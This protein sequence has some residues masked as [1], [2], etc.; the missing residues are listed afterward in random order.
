M[1]KY[2]ILFA[3]LV[4]IFGC[5]GDNLTG[6]S[7]GSANRMITDGWALYEIGEYNSALSKFNG[8]L[9]LNPKLADV[10]NGLGWT[11]FALH[12]I[13]QAV[14]QFNTGV[15]KSP[16][17]LDVIVGSAFSSY[18]NNDFSVETGSIK[19]ALKAVEVDS[20]EFDMNG[21]DY[22][23]SHNPKVTAKE[24]RK[25]M[26]LSYF[27]IGKFED[28]YNQLK[29]YL[30]GYTLDPKASNFPSELLKELERVCKS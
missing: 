14:I 3:I 4:F 11:H 19:W 1:R 23:F 15:G 2:I 24:L 17:S 8:A 7:I 5:G 10:Y 6:P 13:K 9:K 21:V 27:Y 29:K 28:S 26:A 22:V 18:E 25:I 12:N 16:N 20:A 30:N